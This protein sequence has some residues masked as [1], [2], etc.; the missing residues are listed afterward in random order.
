MSETKPKKLEIVKVDPSMH[1]EI[2]AESARLEIFM[3]DVVAL[4]WQAYKEARDKTPPR[5]EN[6][7]VELRK[8][9]VMLSDVLASPYEDIIDGVTRNIDLFHELLQRR[10]RKRD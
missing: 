8:Y 1:K 4:A 2:I 7:P 10:T 6:V 9:L 5:H 3:Y